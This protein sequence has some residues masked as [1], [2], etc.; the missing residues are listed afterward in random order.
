[1]IAHLVGANSCRHATLT[2]KRV[3][4]ELRGDR[5][6]SVNAGD[7]NGDLEEA[8]PSRKKRKLFLNVEKTLTQPELKVYKGI[9]IPFNNKQAAMVKRQFL[10]ATVSANLPFRWTEDPE[11]IKLFLLFRSAAFDVIPAR[12]VLAGRLLDKE[13]SEVELQL[14]HALKGKYATLS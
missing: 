13:S 14:Q 6:A 4:R 12:K 2:A 9:S 1:M 3:A 11:V 10:R 7:E 8:G 5:D